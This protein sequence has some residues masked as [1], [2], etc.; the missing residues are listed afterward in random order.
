MVYPP[1]DGHLYPSTNRAWRR[2]TSLI[3]PTT[4]VSTTLNNHLIVSNDS[5]TVGQHRIVDWE[6]RLSIQRSIKQQVTKSQNTEVHKFEIEYTYILRVNLLYT[7]CEFLVQSTC[8]SFLYSFLI[9]CHGYKTHFTSR[10]HSVADGTSDV[11]KDSGL[12]FNS[13][14]LH[15]LYCA[16]VP[17][18]N[19]SLTHSLKAKAKAK[20]PKY[21]GHIFHRSSSYSAHH[22]FI[23]SVVWV[24]L[25][26][27][28][29][30]CECFYVRIL[31]HVW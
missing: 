24:F 25:C 21:Q 7:S 8:T 19:C 30:L 18:R 17:W 1:I 12:N 28:K 22:F 9:V 29:V 5:D 11:N 14:A 13:M 20:D 3:S 6:P 23:V 15:S 16:D 2:V 31:F 27:H 4:Y 10:F 26:S